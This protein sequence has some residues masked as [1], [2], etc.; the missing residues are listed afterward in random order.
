MT[1]KTIVRT[2]TDENGRDRNVYESGV[3]TYAETGRIAKPA[4]HTIF[5]SQG[6]REMWQQL[7]MRGK[8]SQ[9]RGL[10]EASGQEIPDDVTL[11]QLAQGAGDTVQA[12]TRHFA[13]TFNAS[14]NLR[15][16]AEG[17]RQLIAPM[18]GEPEEVEQWQ[19]NARAENQELTAALT[20]L[21]N[22]LTEHLQGNQRE[23]IEAQFTEK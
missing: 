15:G 6:A 13:Q 21:I 9:L 19:A 5:T 20:A 11:E 12:M 1:T 10:F 22:G 4:P 16:M 3:E 17:Y 2:Y 8:V 14:N 18:I 23:T 7:R